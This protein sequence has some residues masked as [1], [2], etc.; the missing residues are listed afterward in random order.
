MGVNLPHIIIK[1]A[2]KDVGFKTEDLN[3]FYMFHFTPDAIVVTADSPYQT[4]NDLDRRRQGKS[5]SRSRCRALAR[6]VRTTCAQIKFDKMAGTLTT[7]VPFKGTGA[8]RDGPTGQSGQGAMGI[9]N[10]GRGTG[11]GRADAG[12]RHGRTPPAFSGCSRR[13]RSLDL[14]WLA[15]PIAVIALPN[16]ASA[17]TTKMWS[18]MIARDQCGP[19]V[20]AENARWW[21]CACL[22][23]ASDEHGRFHGRTQRRNILNDAREAGLHRSNRKS[24]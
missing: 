4:L 10:G 18:D 3:T 17:E 12:G 19:G 20:P 13:S 8:V 9:H 1:P 11:G 21:V 6:P 23:S 2:Q 5:G 22:T 16:T 7:Y 15:A 24:G 14:T